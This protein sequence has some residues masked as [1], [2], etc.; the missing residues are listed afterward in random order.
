MHATVPHVA[1]QRVD[2]VAHM[3]ARACSLTPVRPPE[4]ATAANFSDSKSRTVLASMDSVVF[5]TAVA[6]AVFRVV[7][8]I[9][10]RWIETT[11]IP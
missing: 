10:D 4:R 5:A 7:S 1:A 6:C 11:L 3:R 8:V 2:V 9:V